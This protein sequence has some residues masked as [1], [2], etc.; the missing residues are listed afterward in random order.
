MGCISAKELLSWEKKQLLKGGNKQ[1]LLL[2]L[3]VVG[4]VKRIELNSL[5]LKQEEHL[6]LKQDLNTL[7]AIWEKHLIKSEPI[8]Y[9]CG[10]S[11]WR[12]LGLI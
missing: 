10:F 7:E 4:G 3:E 1:S 9:L 2:L 11:F 6:Y 12:D 5:R 8:Q